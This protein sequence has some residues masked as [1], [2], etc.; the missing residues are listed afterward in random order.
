MDSNGDKVGLFSPDTQVDG[1]NG[2]A[3]S[4]THT[5]NLGLTTKTLFWIPPEN[6]VGS[7][8]IQGYVLSGVSG[9]SSSQNFYRFVKDDSSALEITQS[10]VLFLNGFE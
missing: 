1:C 3:M 7:V 9:N 5:Q 2:N 4:I 8:F 10:D 6:L